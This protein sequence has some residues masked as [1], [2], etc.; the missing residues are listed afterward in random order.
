MELSRQPFGQTAAGESVELLTLQNQF[1]RCEILTFGATLRSLQ[2]PDRSGTPV[3]VVLG[4]DTLQEYANQD[5]Y[6]GA[7]VGRYANRIAGGH[8]SLNGTDYTLAVN[9]G[10]NHLHGGT[11]GFSYKVWT[12]AELTPTRTVLT[13]RS[14]DGDEGYPGTLDVRVT[15]ALE[16]RSLSIRYEACSDRDTVCNLTNHAYFNLGG[17]NSGPVL[18]QMLSLSARYY[19]PTDETSIPLGQL[20]EV[21]G[22]PLD[23]QHAAAIG[24]RIGKSFTQLIQAQGYDHNYVVD[25]EIG[26]LRPAAAARCSATGIEMTV[27]TTMPGIQLYTANFLE[28]GRRGKQAAVY[29]PR[30]AFCLET[31]FYPDA[32]NQPNFPSATLKA[33]QIYDHETRFTF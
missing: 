31:Q 28:E 5:G 33:G 4:Y 20:E 3:D 19:T 21:A 17:H 27:E 10:P 30:H 25:G 32:P 23:F 26:V 22:T 15:Y 6:L 8:F 14:P 7:V 12:V 16:G 2:V 13:L 1:L 29:G 9:N 18:D 24:S 11:V